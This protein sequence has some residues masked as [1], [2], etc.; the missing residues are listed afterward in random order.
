MCEHGV[1]TRAVMILSER[2]LVV[3]N[4]QKAEF[5]RAE[6]AGEGMALKI[7]AELRQPFRF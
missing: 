7:W 2:Y 3:V 4:S 6:K 5:R 1:N